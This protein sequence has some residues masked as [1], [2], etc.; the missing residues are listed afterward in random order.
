MRHDLC[1][2]GRR[3]HHRRAA[4]ARRYA[5][6]LFLLCWSFGSVVVVSVAVDNRVTVRLWV[7]AGVIIA[8]ALIGACFRGWRIG[9]RID[10]QTG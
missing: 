10:T 5:L 3:D 6:V 1:G 2:H 8:S 9:L 7:A 4:L